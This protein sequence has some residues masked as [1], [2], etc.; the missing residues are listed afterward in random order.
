MSK[1][2]RPSRRDFLD[3]SL[4]TCVALGSLTL[5]SGAPFA[6]PRPQNDNWKVG[7]YTRPWHNYDYRVSFDAIVEAGYRH[8]GLMSHRP[9]GSE[10]PG[11]IIGIETTPKE[12]LAVARELESRNLQ[13]PSV[14]GGGLPVKESLQAGIDGMKKLIDNCAAVGARSVLMGGTG[15]KEL[16]DLYYRAIAENCDYAA[17]NGVIVNIKPHGGTNT[18][19]PQCRQLIE[20]VGHD[21]FTLWYDPGNIYYYTDGELDPVEDSKTVN[22]LVQNGMSVKDFTMTRENGEARKEVMLTPGEGWVDFPKVMANL[23]QG[24]FTSGDL[25]VECVSLGD[26]SLSFIAKEARKAREFVEQLVASL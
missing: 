20:S 22:G 26:G 10:R 25:V 4:K 13:V 15:R 14:W 1:D 6:R 9:E 23:V 12:A 8:I 3:R 7:I 16:A 11:S 19:G 5:A 17:E 24:G 2:H 18:T 21:N